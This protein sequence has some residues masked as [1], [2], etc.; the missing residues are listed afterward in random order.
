MSLVR[1]AL[2]SL[3]VL[4][5]AHAQVAV[6]PGIVTTQPAPIVVAPDVAKTPTPGGPVPVP[7][8]NV[9]APVPKAVVTPALQPVVPIGTPPTLA[10]PSPGKPEHAGKPPHAGKP[11]FAGRPENP[12]KPE[13]AGRP[14]F[15]GKPP[16]A[17]KP[18]LAGQPELVAKPGRPLLTPL[19]DP[20]L[21]KKD[22]LGDQ[23]QVDQQ[24]LQEAMQKKSQAE[25]Q[26]SQAMKKASDTQQGI[27]QNLK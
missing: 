16:H 17:A 5:V 1:V 20:R 8:P 13:H 19:D 11:D 21:G 26:Q 14:D 12:G 3:A 23:S 10:A 18:D 24:K 2:A 25:Q 15:A 9:V 6:R 7:Y 4:P 22:G 27:V